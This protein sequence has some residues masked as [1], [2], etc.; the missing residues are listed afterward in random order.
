MTT[1]RMNPTPG[2][3]CRISSSRLEAKVSFIHPLLKKIDLLLYQLKRLQESFN[4]DPT[5]WRE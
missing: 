5:L 3:V 4:R 2:S 1:A